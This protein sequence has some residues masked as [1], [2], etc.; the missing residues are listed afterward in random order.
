MAD[1]ANFN[2]INFQTVAWNTAAPAVTIGSGTNSDLAN[3]KVSAANVYFTGATE[4]SK[5]SQMTLLD[6]SKVAADKQVQAGNL[7]T[8]SA[9]TLGTGLQGTGSL[10]L[11]AQGN[12]LYTIETAQL[13]E[14]IHNVLMGQTAV[15][16][17]LALS[18]DYMEDTLEGLSIDQNKGK[19]G[20]AVYANMGGGTMRQTTG[21]YIN[22][23]SWNGV[24]GLGTKHSLLQG[25][26]EYGAFVEHGYAKYSTHN[27]THYGNGTTKYTGGGLLAKWTTKND[28]YLEGSVKSGRVKDNSSSFLQ[29]ALGN[30]YGYNTR[31]EYHGAHLG[32]GKVFQYHDDAQLDVY[33]KY[34]YTLKKGASFDAGGHYDLDNV[35][36]SLMRIGAR[37]T[38]HGASF[39]YYAGLAYEH[40]FDGQGRG[41]YNGFA[42][43][44]ADIKGGSARLELGAKLTPNE[45]S[46]WGFDLNLTGYAG[47][48]RGLSGS[49]SAVYQF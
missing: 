40:E 17:N 12:V 19:E 43:R 30:T 47:Q 29:D 7:T 27:G 25:A 14:Q 13:N 35:K 8:A 22:S 46:P 11:D 20:L 48:K 9:Y 2:T 36:S 26:I 39:D 15:L 6:E 28:L 45:S 41:T 34:F 32:I 5:G 3:T 37:Y 38:K 33:G 44:S 16:S 18:H 42:L 24:L 1:I 31:S 10:S 4:L 23:N 49:V 21:S